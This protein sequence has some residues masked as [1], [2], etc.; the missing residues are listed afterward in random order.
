MIFRVPDLY[1]MFRTYSRGSRPTVCVFGSTIMCIRKDYYVFARTSII[2]CISISII[3]IWNIICI[4]NMNTSGGQCYSITTAEPLWR[5][6]SGRSC[7]CYRYIWVQD[8]FGVIV[9]FKKKSPTRIGD[10][11]FS[12]RAK[13][14]GGRRKGGRLQG[15]GKHPIPFQ[16]P[17]ATLPHPPAAHQNTKNRPKTTRAHKTIRNG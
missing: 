1:S 16:P 13:M 4:C 11:P 3:C 17:N 14:F 12:R 7:S 2:I 9:S 6:N 15:K 8:I 5:S 10:E